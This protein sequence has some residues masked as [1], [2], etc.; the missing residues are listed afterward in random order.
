M[1]DL[2]IKGGTVVDGSGST[3]YMA[4]VAVSDG[5]IVAV[6]QDLGS[7]ER[8][9]D[10]E[11]CYV[12][13]GFVDIHTHYDGQATWDQEMA[14]SAWHGITTVVMGNCGVGFAPAAQD[15][16]RSVG[17]FNLA[18]GVAQVSR[19]RAGTRNNG[20]TRGA[21]RYWASYGSSRLWRLRAVKRPDARVE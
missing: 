11:G 13:P 10:A 18:H 19:R 2:L 21:S 1:Y 5:L 20:D 3:P 7:A 6:G 14:P 17:F 8:E 9:I 15:T 4:D 12:T 16:G